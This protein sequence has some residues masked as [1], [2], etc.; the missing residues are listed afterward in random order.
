MAESRL[1]PD[2]M[3]VLTQRGSVALC[4]GRGRERVAI[5]ASAAECT[6]P[7][8]PSQMSPLLRLP[9]RAQA[10][11]HC[12]HLSTMPMPSDTKNTLFFILRAGLLEPHG[13]ETCTWHNRD[14]RTLCMCC[15]NVLDDTHCF[16]PYMGCCKLRK[17]QAWHKGQQYH[18]CNGSHLF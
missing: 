12:C 5:D 1:S 15:R 17:Y 4:D 16:S 13:S 9:L 3:H 14:L 18:T 2:T 8:S 11:R 7:H 10:S 6:A